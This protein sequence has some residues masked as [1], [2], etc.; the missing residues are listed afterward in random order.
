MG[1]S[2]DFG[3]LY[4]NLDTPLLDRNARAVTPADVPHRLRGWAT[5]SLPRRIV[6]SPAVDW[7]TGFPYSALDV[8][9]RYI[10]E[11]NM[12]R[13]PTYFSTD[14]TAFKTFDIFRGKWISACSFSI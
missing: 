11:P 3:T 12:K 7:R 9:Q 8:Y 13:Y 2:N 10:L 4:T 6:V 5:F 1:E 14:L